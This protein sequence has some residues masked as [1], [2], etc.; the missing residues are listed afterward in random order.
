ME[1]L[2]VIAVF[3]ICASVCVKILS[4]SYLMTVEAV[5]TRN[6]LLVAESAAE[7]HKAFAGDTVRIAEILGGWARDG[8]VTVYYDSNW[9]PVSEAYAFF[10]LRLVRSVADT[11]IIFADI[12]V[13]TMLTGD[14]LVSLTTAVRRSAR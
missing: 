13:S 12:S 2:I 7:S 3:A 10:V 4:V 9:Q 6:A 8:T 11:P 14:E 1:Q 5:S